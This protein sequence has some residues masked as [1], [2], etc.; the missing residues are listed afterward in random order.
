MS[1]ELAKWS[2]SIIDSAESDL[3]GKLGIKQ[4]EGPKLLSLGKMLL[5]H[6]FKHVKAKECD[7]TEIKQKLGA[8]YEDYVR[9]KVVTEEPK[10]V[11]GPRMLFAIEEIGQPR[12]T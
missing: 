4:K 1:L 2:D 5:E 10:K 11:K 6:G 12:S 8:N 3:L 7:E 9:M